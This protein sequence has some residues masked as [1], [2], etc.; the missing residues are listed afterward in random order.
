MTNQ[1][2]RDQYIKDLQELE[3][4]KNQIITKQLQIQGKLE[5]I[6]EIINDES[7]QEPKSEPKDSDP[8]P[9]SETPTA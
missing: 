2:K 6:S 9:K 5:L 3:G 8:A 1:E 4:Q 7:H